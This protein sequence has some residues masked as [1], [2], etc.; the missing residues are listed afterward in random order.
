MEQQSEILFD[1]ANGAGRGGS[2]KN[3]QENLKL[4][5]EMATV[6]PIGILK[7]MHVLFLPQ[8]LCRPLIKELVKEGLL[9]CERQGT[10]YKTTPKGQRWLDR[11]S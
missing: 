3:R 1:Q 10:L 8:H 6:H 5:L 9:E 4:I 2:V 11:A 7:I